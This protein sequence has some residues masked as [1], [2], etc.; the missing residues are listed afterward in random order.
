M[1]DTFL[2]SGALTSA[3]SN[4]SASAE[5]AFSAP[6]S[7]R[8]TLDDKFY[9]SL[10]LTTDSATTVNFGAL[11]EANVI[12]VKSDRKVMLRLTSTDGATQAVPVDSF[13]LL[14]SGD[15]GIT[16]IDATR[17]A[18]QETRLVIFLGEQAS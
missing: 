18:G 15:V 8:M 14:M 5:V 4:T 1:A 2:F 11:S 6:V 17:V 7:E 16:A 12:M 10:T 9:T 3:S 13:F